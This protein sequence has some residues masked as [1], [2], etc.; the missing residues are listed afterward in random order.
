MGRR[1]GLSKKGIDA[2]WKK[3]RGRGE[4]GDYKPWWYV[5]E[6]PSRGQS[7]RVLGW[8]TGRVH[9]LLSRNELGYFYVL[10][11]SPRVVD[12]REQFP[13]W[14]EDETRGIAEEIGIEHPSPPGSDHW[15]ITSDFRITLEDGQEVVRTVK[16][17]EELGKPR[18]VEKLEIERRYWEKRGI[19]WGIVLDEDLPPSLVKNIR[20][21]HKHRDFDRERPD[22]RDLPTITSYLTE[23][24]MNSP[25]DALADIARR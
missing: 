7:S 5:N 8:K 21:L 16:P 18:V 14:P 22:T 2:R 6:V 25:N 15:I 9:H 1:Q 13:L 23:E 24:V 3:G 17:A 4:G 20:W 12:I 19:G 10:E 11:W